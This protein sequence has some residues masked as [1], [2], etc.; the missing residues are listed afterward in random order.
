MAHRTQPRLANTFGLQNEI[1]PACGQ[2][3]PYGVGS[4]P[5]AEC[6]RCGDYLPWY[7]RHME[8]IEAAEDELEAYY[9]WRA[10]QQGADQ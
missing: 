8:Q 10:C 4:K 9:A 1:C 5:P 7:L 3:H 6:D 2:C